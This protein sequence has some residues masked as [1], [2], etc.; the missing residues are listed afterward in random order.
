MHVTQIGRVIVKATQFQ[1]PESVEVE[2]D[3]IRHDR[4][5]ALV[6]DDDTFVGSAQHSEFI[7]LKFTL[8]GDERELNLEMPDGRRVDGPAAADGRAFGIDHFGL[9]TIEVAE[10]GG[11]WEDALSS[12]AGRRIRLVRCASAGRSIDVFPVTFVTTASLGRL[13]EE[14]GEAVDPA[15]F[16]AGFVLDHDAA[17]EEDAWDGRELRIGAALL[18]VRTGVPRCQVTGYNPATGASDQPVMKALIKYREKVGLPDGMMPDY[19]TPG[20]ATYAEVLEP[21][22]VRV[23][24]RAELLG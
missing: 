16:R 11:P 24:D 10:V 2:R 19:A 13:A 20:F 1:H 7:P 5:F 22:S 12:F 8:S 3:G 23:G 6:E 9:R 4:A 21:G 17:H 18:R 14:V 15:R